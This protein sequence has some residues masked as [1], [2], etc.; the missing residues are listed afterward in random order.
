MTHGGVSVAIAARH[1]T[2]SEE[3]LHLGL[4]PGSAA[5][6]NASVRKLNMRLGW[7]KYRVTPPGS[8]DAHD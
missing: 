7:T 6:A 2:S 3:Y 1:N 5:E 8:G 4:Y